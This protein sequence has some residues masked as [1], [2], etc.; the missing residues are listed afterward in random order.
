MILYSDHLL[1]LDY[2]TAPDILFVQ[3]QANKLHTIEQVKKAFFSIVAA[4]REH[5]IE[6]ILL[7]LSATQAFSET[8]YNAIIAQLVV[9][10]R[11]TAIRKVARVGTTDPVREQK[12]ASTYQQIQAAV[13]LPFEYESFKSRID[14]LTWLMHSSH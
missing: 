13:E 14:A 6:R 5:R 12:V 1:E 8:E 11:P 4:T 3:W 7:D 2:A 9:G 10:L